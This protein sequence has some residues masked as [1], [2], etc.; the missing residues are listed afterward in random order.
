MAFITFF[1][2]TL[3]RLLLFLNIFT[4]LI[5]AKVSY[6]CLMARMS[7]PMA[8]VIFFPSTLTRLLL[9]LNT[10][11]ELN[12]N[13]QM[14]L[15]PLTGSREVEWKVSRGWNLALCMCQLKKRKG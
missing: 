12:E 5:T 2:S 14:P 4:E 9:F 6:L 15:I 1:P 3:T 8:F 11:T 13:E 10:F 7:R